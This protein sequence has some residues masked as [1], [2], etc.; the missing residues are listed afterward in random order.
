MLIEAAAK[1]AHHGISFGDVATWVAVVVALVFS[2]IA[3]LQV[4]KANSQTAENNRIAKESNEI[5]RRADER[6]ERSERRETE[7]N[8]VVWESGWSQPGIWTVT[9]LGRDSACAATLV[10]R[11]DD[12]SHVVDVDNVGSGESTHVDL[13]DQRNAEAK[14]VR[15]VM[16]S[17]H[18]SGVAYIA[19]AN[20]TIGHRLTWKSSLGTWHL[21][22]AEPKSF[23]LDK[24]R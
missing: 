12:E 14:R 17:A 22:V 3:A 19:S 13:N 6:S 23:G 20:L 11:V 24:K 7:R 5:A 2:V 9:N 1:T 16:S 18:G 21:D 10:L 15:D 8:D 4:R